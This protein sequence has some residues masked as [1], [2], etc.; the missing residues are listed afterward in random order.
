MPGFSVATCMYQQNTQENLPRGVSHESHSGSFIARLTSSRLK[1]ALLWV[2]V[3]G[4][5]TGRYSSDQ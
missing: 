1:L 4:L 3:I 2:V 5:A